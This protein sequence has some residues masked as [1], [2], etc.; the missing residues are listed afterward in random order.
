MTANA[1]LSGGNSSER[2]D[3]AQ[4]SFSNI[5]APDQVNSAVIC[6]SK[7]GLRAQ[8]HITGLHYPPAPGGTCI[9]VVGDIH[10]RA[11]LL[12]QVHLRID[13]D[14][15]PH[16][17]NIEIY[18]GDYIDRGDRSKDV[19]DALIDRSRRNSVFCLR[20]NHEQM[21]MDFL[22]GSD[23]ALLTAAVGAAPTFASYGVDP[24]LSPARLLADLRRQIPTEHLEFMDQTWLYFDIGDYFFAHAGVRP[25]VPLRNQVPADL[26]WIREEFLRGYVDSSAIVV[27]GHTPVSEPDFRPNRINIDTGAYVTNRLTCLR[28]AESG[29]DLLC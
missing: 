7:P 27:H 16:L 24:L 25:N 13:A 2:L 12:D 28:I 26:L 21:L 29:P 8:G 17:D 19:I 23:I 9:Y 6:G 18:I 3:V 5:V 14:R 10:G 4:P 22:D 11:D 1:G 15:S 20:G